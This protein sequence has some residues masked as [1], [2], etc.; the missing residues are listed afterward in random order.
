MCTIVCVLLLEC[1]YVFVFVSALVCLC[2]YIRLCMCVLVC[3][4]VIV[5]LSILV[6]VAGA[7]FVA[8]KPCMLILRGST[9]RTTFLTPISVCFLI[10][11][12]F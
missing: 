11:C 9:S 12:W 5:C 2:G 10:K 1:E 8:Y 7:M 3:L 6:C 4:Y